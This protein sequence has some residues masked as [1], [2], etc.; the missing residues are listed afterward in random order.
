MDKNGF[1][2][3]Y[4][5]IIVAG[6]KPCKTLIIKKNLNPKWEPPAEAKFTLS[7]VQG[8]VEVEVWDKVRFHISCVALYHCYFHCL[9]KHFCPRVVDEQIYDEL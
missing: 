9:I 5:R 7:D 4:C 8:V 1:S 2:D 3:P 6:Q